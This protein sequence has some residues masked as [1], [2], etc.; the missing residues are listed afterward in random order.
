MYK[1]Y[2]NKNGTIGITNK[3]LELLDVVYSNDSFVGIIEDIAENSLY[4]YGS[5]PTSEK[6]KTKIK[7]EK[8]NNIHYINMKKD[9]INRLFGDSQ[10]SYL[11]M[12]LEEEPYIIN[13]I[14]CYKIIS[15]KE[16]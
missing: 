13:N 11:P 7:Y 16:A 2:V 8:T 15:R 9:A 4:L 10:K 1:L 5:T 14:K 12:S 3:S 6:Y